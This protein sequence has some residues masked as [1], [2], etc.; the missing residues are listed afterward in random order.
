MALSRVIKTGNGTT[1]QFVV[2]FALGYLD[3]ADVT[4]RV[5]TEADGTGQPLYRTITFLSESLM[6]ISGTPPADGERVVF[7]RTVEK[8]DTIVHFS[9]GDVMDEENLDLSFKQILMVVHEVLDGRF[10]AFDSD[11]DLGGF[12]I[13]GLGDPVD[14]DDAANKRY[15][16]ARIQ[17]G[18]QQVADA[19][20]ARDAAIAAR[21]AAQGSQTAAG[22]SATAA[23]G[24]ASSASGSATAAAGSAS[25]A[26]AYR[27]TA[28]THATTATNKA[29][30]AA[31]SASTATTKATEAS[32]SATSAAT[33]RDLAQKWATENED[34]VVSGGQ[35][36]ARHHALKAAASA[37]AAQ[38]ARTGSETARGQAQDARDEAVAARSLLAG[39]ANGQLLGKNS[40]AD[41]D[42]KWVTLTGGGDMLRSMY[43]PQDK[44]AD[45]FA[46]ENF[47]GVPATFPPAAH[48]HTAAQITDLKSM[49]KRNLTVSTADPTGGEDGDVHF[50][51]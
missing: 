15:V 37:S 39:G 5:G 48:T 46:W 23:A 32:G 26:L 18:T 28:G 19:Q 10:G 12:L 51:V 9:N 50:K 29:T 8:E 44:Q 20:A 2:D 49:A 25:D 42:Y 27:N 24:S 4:C 11:L 43:D 33:A 21:N 6:Q 34:T 22:N 47:T 35:Y 13:H 40:N 41:Y 45:A 31:G 30:E 3:P 36:S 1:N 16:D 7:E 38:T 14:A 17:L